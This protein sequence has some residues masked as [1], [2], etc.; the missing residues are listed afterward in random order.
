MNSNVYGR[1]H[2]NKLRYKELLNNMNGGGK[3]KE[4]YILRHGE[5]EANEANIAQ[6]SEYDT[7][8]TALGREQGEKTGEYLKKYRIKDKNFDAIY[9]SPLMRALETAEIISD[10][11]EFD[12]DIIQEKRLVERDK[13]RLS[14]M[15]KKGE[16]IQS[17]FAEFDK[18]N[19]ENEDPIENY[20]IHFRH[21]V[22][23]KVSDK[24]EFGGESDYDADKRATNLLEDIIDT[25]HSKI[26]IVSHGGLLAGLIRAM[27]NTTWVPFVSGGNC[28]LAYVTYESDEKKCG[29]YRLESPP[30]RQHIE[31]K[32]Q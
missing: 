5:S 7:G 15:D 23:Q 32:D 12:G 2:V 31:I 17:V 30:N 10:I 20:N 4:I 14:G 29:R 16:L 11:I 21:N 25:D 6:G 22:Y 27:I 18:L 26:L 28:W 9:S 3:R 1:Y 24:Y 19:A 8:L 13:G